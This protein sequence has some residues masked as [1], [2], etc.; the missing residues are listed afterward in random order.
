MRGCRNRAKLMSLSSQRALRLSPIGPKLIPVFTIGVFFD[1][2]GEDRM[3]KGIARRDF[4]LGSAA[5]AGATATSAFTCVEIADAA[6]IEVPTV[7]KLSVRVLVDS[8]FDLF[9]RPKQINGVAIAPAPRGG[10]FRKSLHNE[11]G[12]S[13]WLESEGGGDQRTLMLDYGYTPDVLLNNMALIGVDPSKLDAL[14][15]SHGHYDHFGG[16]LGFLDK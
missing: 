12:L 7:D 4:L 9:F 13:L 5:L 14:I 10:D 3:T 1:R 15:V 16:L 6:P 2:H 11:W 8:S